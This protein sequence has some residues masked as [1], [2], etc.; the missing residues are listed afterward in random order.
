[1]DKYTVDI[2]DGNGEAIYL[3]VETS[4]PI[5]AR[6]AAINEYPNAKRIE[7]KRYNTEKL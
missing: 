7:V 1:M 3:W 4:S 5:F 2:I 6:N